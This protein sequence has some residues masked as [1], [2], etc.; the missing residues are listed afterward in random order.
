MTSNADRP[1]EAYVW[2]WLPGCTDPVV[3]GRLESDGKRYLFNYGRSYL[4][5][6]DRLPIY[7]PELPL[8]RGQLAPS[9]QLIIANC[10]R[11]GAPDAWGRRVVINRLTGLTGRAASE[12]ELDELTFMLESG[13]DRVGALDF[14]KSASHYEPRQTHKVTLAEMATSA[15]RVEQGLPLT[16]ALALALQ[17]GTAIGGARPKVLIES[18]DSK[19]VAKFSSSTDTF[20]V[21]KAEYVA[22]Q[23]AADA[24]INVAPVTLTSVLKKDILLV[25]RFDRTQQNGN[26]TRH[27]M[28]SALTL[29]ALD[30]LMAAH[31]SYQDLATIV[32]A[33][34]TDAPETLRE[35]FA[36]LTFSIL[37]GNTDDHARN[38]AAFWNGDRL[39]LTPAYDICPQ[40]RLGREASQGMLVHNADRRSQLAVAI[41]AAHHFLLH[42]DDALA[43]VRHQVHLVRERW[44]QV[45]QEADLTEVDRNLMWRR[46]FLNPYALEG[47]EGELYD[48]IDDL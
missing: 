30:E 41:N 22:M 2:I 10:L 17:H 23:L 31:A 7:L 16:P 8:K 11:D 6:D 42:R 26:W 4:D 13:S 37:V 25:E 29:L 28:V 38:H 3:A 18:D 1:R 48:L 12:V 24:G 36:R 14:Q 39:T 9:P 43:M 5:R 40:P 15:E 45:C 34:F 33:R 46:Q 47:L 35:L 19:F 44:D 32:R 27:A 20:S 21:V